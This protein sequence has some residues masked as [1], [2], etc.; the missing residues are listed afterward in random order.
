MNNLSKEN[1]VLCFGFEPVLTGHGGERRSAQL[2]ELLNSDNIKTLLPQGDK[3]REFSKINQY[4]HG[5]RVCQNL[6]IQ[7]NSIR[8]YGYYGHRYMS[9][10]QIYEE[11]AIALVTLWEATYDCMIPFVAKLHRHKI[12]AAPQNIESL[13][14][15]HLNNTT[16]DKQIDFKFTLN[17]LGK[18]LHFL[19][20]SDLVFCISREEQW[21]LRLF[22]IEAYYLPYYPPNITFD[23]L[24]S[25]RQARESSHKS[26]YLILGSAINT[27]TLIGM[28]EQVDLLLKSCKSEN[29]VI[30]IV[31]YGTEKLSEFYKKSNV[32]VIGSVSEEELHDILLGTKAI[33]IHQK[34]GAGALTKIPEMLVAGIPIIA[35]GNAC[36]SSF[37]YHGVYCYD[38]VDKLIDLMGQELETPDIPVRPVELENFFKDMVFKFF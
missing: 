8:N 28:I 35:N 37:Q 11:N 7:I 14:P 3:D 25:I 16:V 17:K 20:K 19:A 32:N 9:L 31:G 10:S 34:A 5:L 6:P 38:T 23:R 13:V 30:D 24:L 18:E 26:K 22:G 36:R 1:T 29:L 4:Y 15:I 2:H 12:I 33:L 27:P 21:L